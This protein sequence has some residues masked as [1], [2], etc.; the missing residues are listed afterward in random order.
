MPEDDETLRPIREALEQVH[1]RLGNIIAHLR[2]REEERYLGWRCTGCGYL[3][4]FTRPMPAHV[5]SPCP[6]C[7][8]VTFQSVP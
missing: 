5:A 4:H 3:K 8:G 1:A 7:K 2:P 6:K